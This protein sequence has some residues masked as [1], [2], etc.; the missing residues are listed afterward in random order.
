MTC[1]QCTSYVRN[2]P[3][4]NK[5]ATF[6]PFAMD[7]IVGKVNINALLLDHFVLEMEP[8]GNRL[9]NL[10]NKEVYININDVSSEDLGQH[11]GKLVC[12]ETL[13]N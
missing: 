4:Q 8:C 12:V 13:T 6:T 2:F 7:G 5:L 11:L 3:L 9:C 10:Q 1:N